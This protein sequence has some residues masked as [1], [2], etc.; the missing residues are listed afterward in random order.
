ML[1]RATATNARPAAHER[2]V[3]LL[4][5]ELLGS[6]IDQAGLRATLVDTAM[7]VRVLVCLTEDSGGPLLA[8]VTALG[9]ETQLL[10]GPAVAAPATTALTARALPGTSTHDLTE[11]ALALS[12]IVLVASDLGQTALTRNITALGKPTV[13]PGVPLPPVNPPAFPHGLDPDAAGWRRAIGRKWCGRI[14]AAMLELLA[15]NWRGRADGGIAESTRRLRLCFGRDWKPGAYFAPDEWKG[16]AP[17][18]TAVDASSKIVRWFDILDRSAVYGSYLHRDLVWLEHLGASFA[19]LAAVAGALSH[20]GH[21]WGVVELITLFAVAMMVLSVRGSW[22]QDRWTACRFGAEQLRIARMSL[23]LLVLPPALATTDLPPAADKAKKEAEFEFQALTLVKRIVREH[24]LSRLDPGLTPM[25][26]AQWLDLIVKH[27]IAYHQRNERKLE[28]AETRL[29]FATQ[30]LFII[31]M[32]AVVAHFFP[33]FADAH[34][35]LLFTA[36]GPAFAAA[37]QGTI[38]RLGIV[39]RAAL[40]ADAAR[41]LEEIHDQIA[42][43]MKAPPPAA[44]AWS[45][46]RRLAYGSAKAMG[47]ENTS[48]HRLVRR[49]RD[50]L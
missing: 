45:E 37:L 17:D 2:T 40:S 19:V 49:Y 33:L 7:P 41:E 6:E 30:A 5:P 11:L 50:D 10:L 3:I 43:L 20:H 23:P 36:A 25:A 14:Q 31:A 46:V 27:Q 34:W 4:L 48:W 39:H 24:G 26:A 9:V 32:I 28:Y 42:A 8:A 13:A 35:L 38:T 22:L 18:H 12:D 29:R 44:D 47:R 16:L 15:F 21:I 1:E